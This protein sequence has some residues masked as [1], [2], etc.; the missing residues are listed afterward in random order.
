[1]ALPQFTIREMLEAG[2]H[3]G[4]RTRRWNPLMQQYI[5]GSRN[6]IH[7]ID[8]QQTVP[9]MYQ[10]MAV[11]RQ[12]A[13]SG[14]RVLFVGSKRQAQEIVAETAARCG[15]YYVNHR[16]LGGML[17]NWKTINNSIKR[18]KSLEEIMKNPEGSNKTKKELLEL[19]RECEKLQRALGGIKDMGGLPDVVFVIDSNKENIAIAEA[20]KLG[21]PVIAVLDT[22]SKPHGVDYP[23]PGNDDS[24][25][26]LRLYCRLI[27]DSILDGI[28]E[29]VAKAGASADKGEAGST[30]SSGGR[31]TVV[32]LSS[33]AAAVAAEDEKTET[34]TEVVSKGEAEITKAAA[35]QN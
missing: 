13:A 4:H 8:L 12:V 26:A 18:L 27:S 19:S 2:V 29:Q 11:V 3:F 21:I 20:N 10:A 33:K 17:T 9:M 7:I 14:G 22:N 32:N 31:R 16:W 35:A 23:I 34:E 28:S 30:K 1:M 24:T 6:G 25:R 5:Y 15:Q